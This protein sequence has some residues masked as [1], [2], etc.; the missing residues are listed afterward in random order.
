MEQERFERAQLFSKSI[1]ATCWNV[2]GA[3][4]RP[5]GIIAH[6]ACYRM[7]GTSSQRHNNAFWNTLKADILKFVWELAQI[8]WSIQKAKGHQS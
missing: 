1:L 4:E 7:E 5:K 6:W 3:L 2:L 8:I